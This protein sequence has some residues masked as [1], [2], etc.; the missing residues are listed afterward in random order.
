MGVYNWPLL[1]VIIQLGL[2]LLHDFF[3]FSFVT[4]IVDSSS[5]LCWDFYQKIFLFCGERCG[6]LI[7]CYSRVWF[8]Q[9]CGH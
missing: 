3:P 1:S 9:R 5:L 4:K 6:A 8:V 7:N 2:S